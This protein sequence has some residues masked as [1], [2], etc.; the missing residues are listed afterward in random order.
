MSKSSR[1]RK[2]KKPNPLLKLKRLR[3]SPHLLIKTVRRKSKL[4]RFKRK[5]QKLTLKLL[6]QSRSKCKSNT[7][8]LQL[9]L[10]KNMLSTF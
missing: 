10:R 2:K 9:P 8:T 7:K 3:N 5:N 1:S 6:K 4:L